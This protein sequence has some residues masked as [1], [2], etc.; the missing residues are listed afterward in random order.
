MT[1]LQHYGSLANLINTSEYQLSQCAGLGPRKAKKLIQIFN[2][3]F[4]NK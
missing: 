4:L 2:N 1:L 3:P